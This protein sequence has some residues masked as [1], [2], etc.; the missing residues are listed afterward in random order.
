[1]QVSYKYHIGQ[2]FW[3]PRVTRICNI[4]TVVV[5]GK[6]YSRDIDT[7]Y[8]SVKEKEIT[9]VT[10]VIGKDI[11]HIEY[12]IVNVENPEEWPSNINE[13]AINCRTKEEAES[14]AAEAAA[15]GRECYDY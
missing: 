2:R 12:G 3:V 7:Y 15:I 14:D 11:K 6:K 8:P 9:E 10:I 4:E 1:M 13:D 5:D